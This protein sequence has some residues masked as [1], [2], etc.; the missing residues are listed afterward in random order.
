MALTDPFVLP[1]GTVL[2]PVRD[3]PENLRR[4][5][6]A[7]EEDFAISRPNSR[8]QSKIIDAEAAA[9]VRQFE[10][11]H[12]IAQAV[13]RYSRGK[14]ENPA[15]LLEEA[16]PLLQSLI[17]SQLLVAADSEEAQEIK[18]TLAA[19]E[20]VEGWTVTSCVQTLEDT[21]L[22]QVRGADGQFAALKIAR[23]GAGSG[24]RAMLDREARVLASLDGEVAPRL[25]QSGEWNERRYLLIEWCAGADVSAASEEI[26]R[27][28]FLDSRSDLL[29]LAKAILEAY[30][31]LHEQGVV[32]GDIHPRNVLIDRRQSVKIIDFGLACAIGNE[33]AGVHRGGVGFFLEPEFARA[34]MTGGYPPKLTPAG[35]QYGVAALLYLLFTGKHSLEFSLEKENMMRQIAEEP[36][37][38][39][40]KRG[41]HPWPEVETLLAKAMSKLPADRFSCMREFSNALRAV[42]ISN[43]AAH[44]PDATDRQLAE[45]KDSLLKQLGLAG[46]LLT[47]A[48]L[49]APSTSINYGAAGIAYALYR[50]ACATEDAEMLALADAWSERAVRQIGDEG[51]FYNPEIEITPETVGRTALYH[52]PVGVHAVWALIA[53]V[54]GDLLLQGAATAAFIE[55]SSGACDKLDVTLGRAGNLLGCSFLLGAIQAASSQEMQPVDQL[56]SFAKQTVEQLWQQ[57]D[58]FAPIRECK[59]LSNLGVAHGW[60]GLLYA[61][62]CWSAVSKDPLPA[63]IEERLMQLGQCAE[64][65]GRGLRWRWD[66]ARGL[67]EPGGYMPGWCNGTTGYVFLWTLAH[68]LLGDAKYLSWAEGAGWN[69][70]EIPSPIGN[71]CCGMAGQAYALLN[72]YRHT[73]ETAWLSRAREATR[74]AVVVT[75]EAS[76]S[77]DY[78]EFA[79]R[80]ESLYKGDLG[81][82]LLAADLERP[83]RACMPMFELES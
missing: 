60:A 5:V 22:Y 32:H 53:H 45:M 76:K 46:P 55:A 40:S 52:S 13:A 73:G 71:L 9:L 30:A 4:D 31:R 17:A 77:P 2:L 42:K 83:E 38:P 66:M 24:V 61:T 75:R 80:P 28:P 20:V 43:P 44:S 64:L 35:E 67:N 74:H 62:L 63:N 19:D 10:T 79:L 59:E 7:E 8:T 33:T 65:A 11:P 68:K 78:K 16:F 58:G 27:R 56:R 47:G 14:S 34:G 57:I 18:P 25:L 23:A 81:I 41:A 37:L 29:D 50:M 82:V 70:A 36:I 1:A 39:F 49:P 48:P 72:L 15:Q 6:Q 69:A 21:E 26:R 12:T 3:L 54:R 51:A